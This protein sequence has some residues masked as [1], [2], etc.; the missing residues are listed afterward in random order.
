MEELEQQMNEMTLK[1]DG[2]IIES[3]L[4]ALTPKEDSLFFESPADFLLVNS[5]DFPRIFLNSIENIFKSPLEEIMTELNK[6][7]IT[8]LQAVR[9]LLF[10]ELKDL[11]TKHQNHVLM[12]RNSSS[13]PKIVTDIFVIGCSLNSKTDH[14]DLMKILKNEKTEQNTKPPTSKTQSDVTSSPIDSK[15]HT[16]L[17]TVQSPLDITDSPNLSLPTNLEKKSEWQIFSGKMNYLIE[18]TDS[19]HADQKQVLGRLSKL[20]DSLTEIQKSSKE[21]KENIQKL[22]SDMQSSRTANLA[23]SERIQVV[24]RK[25]DKIDIEEIKKTTKK[26]EKI[27]TALQK[28]VADLEDFQK[29]DLKGK[30]LEGRLEEIEEKYDLLQAKMTSLAQSHD[31]KVDFNPEL[32]LVAIGLDYPPQETTETLTDLCK[33]LI[34]IINPDLVCKIVQVKRLGASQIRRGI[35]KIEMDALESKLAILR[36]KRMLQDSRYFYNVFL[37]S[38]QSHECR[39]LEQNFRTLLDELPD[40]QKRLTI[41][42][43]GKLLP[44][45]QINHPHPTSTS[46]SAYSQSKHQNNINNQQRRPTQQKYSTNETYQPLYMPQQDNHQLGPQF[47]MSFAQNQHPPQPQFSQ[48]HPDVGQPPLNKSAMNVAQNPQPQA[49]LYPIGQQLQMRFPTFHPG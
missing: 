12:R 41:S 44:P 25:V 31:G 16:P 18:K 20:E 9:K 26:T 43:H 37:R 13:R 10:Q 21:N 28:Q 33:N 1:E 48:P 38:S 2:L 6:L 39:L 32:T 23:L 15:S 49:L 17:P 24:E 45:R 47:P 8:V 29:K 35:V 7:D 30:A 22:Q 40:L 5:E 3:P 36:K 42:A 46:H 34:H 27:Q 19:I 11:S 4:S 14:E